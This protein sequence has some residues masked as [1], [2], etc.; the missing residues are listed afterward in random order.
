MLTEFFYVSLTWAIVAVIIVLAI[1][2]AVYSYY[3]SDNM[4]SYHLDKY[5][6]EISELKEQ[7]SEA[8]KAVLNLSPTDLHK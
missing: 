1:V 8:K 4:Y 2:I 6:S 3:D 5:R 7:L